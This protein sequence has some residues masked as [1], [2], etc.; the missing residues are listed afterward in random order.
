[1]TTCTCQVGP[2]KFEGESVL[3]FMAYQQMCLGNVDESVG[4]YDFFKA[5]FMFDADASVVD[6]ALEHGYC[7][8]CIDAHDDRTLYGLAIFEDDNGFVYC[9]TFATEADYDAGLKTAADRETDEGDDA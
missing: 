8:A 2:G 7:Q 4:R 6:A 3:T 9:D 5:P 1:M